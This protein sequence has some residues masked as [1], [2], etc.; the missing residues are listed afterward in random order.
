MVQVVPVAPVDARAMPHFALKVVARTRSSKAS[1]KMAPGFV[2]LVPSIQTIAHRARAGVRRCLAKFAIA[3]GPALR[4]KRVLVLAGDSF[5]PHAMALPTG[6]L[7]L[8]RAFVR[9]PAANMAARS[10][11]AAAIK[12]PTVVTR[13]CFLA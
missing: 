6:R 9:A 11:L 10:R 7:P 1:V 3:A 12:I 13:H 8:A 5:A 4:T 2:L